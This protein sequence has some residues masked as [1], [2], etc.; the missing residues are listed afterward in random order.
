MTY[1]PKKVFI[2]QNGNYTEISYAEYCEKEASEYKGRFFISLHGCLME[3]TEEFY[4]DFYR[5]R[6]REKY[7]HECSIEKGDIYYHSL[8]TEEFNG[9]D[10]LIDTEGD[11]EQAIVDKLMIEQ[12]QKILPLLSSD[13]R[14]LIDALYFKDHS[15]RE[16]SKISRVPQKTINDRKHKILQ[17]LKKFLEN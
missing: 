4:K 17:K 1:I 6:R 3:T 7:L 12:L 16:L 11:I 2:L 9:E 13:E 14:E 5:N 8:D 10:I 15:E